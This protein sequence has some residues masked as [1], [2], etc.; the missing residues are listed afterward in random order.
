MFAIGAALRIIANEFAHRI[1]LRAARGWFL[2]A[3]RAKKAGETP[4]YY[5]RHGLDEQRAYHIVCLMVGHDPVRFKDLADEHKLPED[6]RRSCGWDYETGA[7]SWHRV[8]APHLRAEGQPKTS[9]EVIYGDAEGTLAP[10]ARA[11][12]EVRFLELLAEYAASRYLWPAPMVMEMRSC[13]EAGARWTIPTR[14]MHIC[15]ELAQ[16]FAELFSE[17]QRQGRT[18]TGK[19]GTL[20]EGDL[21]SAGRATS[22]FAQNSETLPC[23]VSLRDRYGIFEGL[24]R[25]RMGVVESTAW[26]A[27]CQ[28]GRAAASQRTQ[29]RHDAS[30]D[31]ER[32]HCLQR[33]WR[34]PETRLGDVEAD[35]RNRL[36]VGSSESW[37]PKQHPLS[38]ALTCR[39]RSRP[40]HQEQTSCGE[41]QRAALKITTD[42][43]GRSPAWDIRTTWTLW[44]GCCD[45]GKVG[46]SPSV[47]SKG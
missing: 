7:W 1:L 38:V 6:R 9:I 15:Y 37:G 25:H 18:A 16:E 14:R 10:F 20:T 11:F 35:G 43:L 31:G 12:R 13:G 19:A 34:A 2:S 21:Q 36:H 27:L 5:E 8:M 33:R 17:H 3:R 47:I 23:S 26:L 22:A 4:R 24:N 46:F 30:T 39:W 45:M 32:S 29:E 28:S 44:H 40:Q 42:G 41:A